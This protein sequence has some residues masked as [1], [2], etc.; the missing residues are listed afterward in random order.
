MTWGSS[1]DFGLSTSVWNTIGKILY[2]I[3]L[4]GFAGL[5][6]TSAYMSH[7][8]KV[9]TDR[10]VAAAL[11]QLGSIQKSDSTP[12][13]KARKSIELYLH[14]RDA[15]DAGMDAANPGNT[16]RD[17]VLAYTKLGYQGVDP[18]P[19]GVFVYMSDIDCT[20]RLNPVRNGTREQLFWAWDQF[21]SDLDNW[22][23]FVTSPGAMMEACHQKYD[24]LV[25]TADKRAEEESHSAAERLGKVAGE[26]SNAFDDA[27]KPLRDFCNQFK[28]G[29]KSAKSQ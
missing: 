14:S 27:T 8:D 20:R 25:A 4:V 15:I 18:L 24:A 21:M 26:I 10:E 13:V 2:A 6:I 11:A 22:N 1:G 28:A 16:L 17:R 23:P 3:L 29:F 12:Q 7:R 9:D 19:Q 5:L